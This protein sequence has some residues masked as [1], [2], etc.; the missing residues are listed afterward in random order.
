MRSRTE[1]VLAGLVV[2][3]L[4]GGCADPA[5]DRVTLVGASPVPLVSGVAP[6]ASAPVPLVSGVTP[7]ASAPP[8]TPAPMPP[9]VLASSLAEPVA[10]GTPLVANGPPRFFVTA[11]TPVFHD[12][13]G[14]KTA[15]ATPVRAVVNDAAT[16]AYVADVPLPPG[17]ASSWHLVAAAP[18]NR[19]FALAGWTGLGRSLRFYRVRLDENGKPGEPELVPDA[20]PEPDQATA[21]A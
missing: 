7:P 16:G 15:T 18:D 14:T 5:V 17:V 1:A 8:T 12:V 4:A 6:P 13:P 2:L 11:R 3:S 9:L 21:I 10:T 20:E 19:T